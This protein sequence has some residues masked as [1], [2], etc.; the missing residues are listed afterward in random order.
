MSYKLNPFTGNF[1]QV[2]DKASEIT[3]TGSTSGLGATTVQGALDAIGNPVVKNYIKF[4]NA[5]TNATTGWSLGTVTLT[6]NFPSGTPSFGSGANA[7]LSLT[8]SSSSPISGTYSYS[9]ASSAAT[10]AGDFLAS[11]AFTID[12]ADQ[13]KVM[14]VRFSYTGSSNPS[15][16]NWS[17]TSSNSFGIA[18]YDVT[19]SAWI[20][21]AG[22]W[23]MTQSSGVGTAAA[24]FQTSSSS[25]QYRLVIFNANATSGAATVKF[26]EFYVGPQTTSIGTI[27][28]DWVSY[29]P[30]TQGF[31]T[32]SNMAGYWR[33]VGANIELRV[34]FT[35][36]T[37][38]A[39]EAR[40]YFPTGVTSASTVGSPSTAGFFISSHLTTAAMYVLAEASVTYVTFSMSNATFNSGT[41][42]NGSSLIGGGTAFSLEAR[43]PIAGWSS[44]A[45]MSNDTDTRV[46]A[47]IVS[48]DPA[49]ATSGNPIIVPTIG[50]DSH[51]G[52]NATT[53]RYT[54][55]VSGIYKIF[56]ALQSASS[57]TT[58]TIYKNAVSTALAGNLDSNGEATFAGAVQCNAGDIIDLRPGGTVDAT[59]MTL[60]IERLSGP[61]VVAATE[62]VACRYSNTAGTSISNIGETTVPFA[63]KDYDTHAAFVTD[64]FTVPISGKYEISCSIYFQSGAYSAGNNLYLVVYKNG[65]ATSYGTIVT[66]AAITAQYGVGATATLQC[67]AGDTLLI[68]GSN[69]R[70]GGAT[71]LSTSAGFNWITIKR[72]GN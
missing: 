23:G 47:A 49:S 20:M 71:A 38:T 6:S 55:P 2:L 42:L 54:C 13:A 32:V 9:Y 63:T 29:T 46:V 64:T 4:S 21:P 31:G 14:T 68:K 40:V 18:I 59:N 44:T 26:D 56:G 60:N 28:T 66:A 5:E 50:F 34:K 52:Y 35:V 22:V 17:G 37:P 30:T 16:V 48:G 8:A 7:N 33:R 12:A 24:T 10:T 58:L 45:Q 36:G 11:D 15:N 51:A 27:V 41:K 1:D 65:S 3:Q 43:V 19:A 57:A 67:N 39:T 72:I 69:N 62:T 70:T 25:T 61:S 53:G